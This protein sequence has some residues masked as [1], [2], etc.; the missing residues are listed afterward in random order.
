[1]VKATKLTESSA[2]IQALARKYGVT[3][4]DV[5]RQAEQMRAEEAE[6]AIEVRCSRA[7]DFSMTGEYN[8]AIASHSFT[9]FRD[10]ES[11]W[12][13]EAN[14]GQHHSQCVLGFTKT[15]ALTKLALRAITK[16]T[17]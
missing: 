14:T 8:V 3:Q 5:D 11:G 6:D 16:G 1:M 9:M 2:E 10:R 17:N 15:E 12:W 4:A 7:K 13:Y